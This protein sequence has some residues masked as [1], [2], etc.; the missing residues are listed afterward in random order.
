MYRHDSHVTAPDHKVVKILQ[1][2]VKQVG[3]SGELTG[4]VASCDSNYYSNFLQ[5]PG[6]VFGPGDLIVAHGADEQIE[7]NQ[8]AQAAAA[9]ANLAY[10]WE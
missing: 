6:V 10:Q 7:V 9:M 5:M 4:M 2:G 3:M 1:E 8:I